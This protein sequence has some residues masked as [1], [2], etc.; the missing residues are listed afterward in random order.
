MA[1]R[2]EPALGTGG[3]GLQLLAQVEGD[4]DVDSA[5]GSSAL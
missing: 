4:P 3:L 5:M 2:G 1:V